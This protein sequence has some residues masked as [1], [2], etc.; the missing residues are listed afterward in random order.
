MVVNTGTI[1]T[2]KEQRCRAEWRQRSPSVMSDLIVVAF[3]SEAKAEGVRKKLLAMQKEYLIELGDAGI[4]EKD[5]NG[6]IK[7]HQMIILPPSVPSPA[8]SGAH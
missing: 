2:G 4:A 8:R 5:A 7:L 1:F 6:Q 3:P